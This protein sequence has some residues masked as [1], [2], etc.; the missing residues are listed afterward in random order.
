MATNVYM[1]ICVGYEIINK[2]VPYS[3]LTAIQVS[4]KVVHEKLH[5]EI[6]RNEEYKLIGSG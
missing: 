3:G 4:L 2:K 6:P 1:L 5:P